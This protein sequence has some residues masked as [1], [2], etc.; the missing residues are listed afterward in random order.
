MHTEASAADWQ[1]GESGF[2][3]RGEASSWQ[4]HTLGVLFPSGAPG[5]GAFSDSPTLHRFIGHGHRPNCSFS[6]MPCESHFGPGEKNG[7][8]ESTSTA[9][10]VGA[11][12]LKHVSPRPLCRNDLRRK[13]IQKLTCK[14][15]M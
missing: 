2:F 4:T 8:G 1:S 10:G 11:V 7:L 3:G 15:A 9:V 6:A 13:Y 12:E 14:S 5:G